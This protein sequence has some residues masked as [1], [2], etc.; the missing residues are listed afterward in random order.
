MKAFSDLQHKA[1]SEQN[2]ANKVEVFDQLQGMSFTALFC[3]GGR[4]VEYSVQAAG[5]GIKNDKEVVNP[6]PASFGV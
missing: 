3:Q 6:S 1:S 2:H 5:D 4:M